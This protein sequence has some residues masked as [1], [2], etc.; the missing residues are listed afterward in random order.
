MRPRA[1][2]A[3]RSPGTPWRAWSGGARC[4][5]AWGRGGGPG[6]S[7]TDESVGTAKQCIPF[8]EA[9]TCGY[10]IPLPA[11]MRISVVRKADGG[12]EVK[13]EIT[14]FKYPLVDMHPQTQYPGAPFAN[15]PVLKFLNPWLIRTPPGYSTLFVPPMNR[16]AAPIVPLCGVVETDRYYQEINFPAVCLLQSGASAVLPRGTPLVQVIPFRRESWESSH[17]TWEASLRQNQID[18]VQSNIHAYRDE[19]WQKKHFK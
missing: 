16:F 1:P 15:A 3:T 19:N 2:T 17:G 9:M 14:G 12:A 13:L 18:A 4:R 11:D 6:G 5:S 7:S 8:L 10:I